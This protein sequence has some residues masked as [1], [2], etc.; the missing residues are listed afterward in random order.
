MT[1]QRRSVS[2]NSGHEMKRV[3]LLPVLLNVL[4]VNSTNIV[5]WL[6]IVCAAVASKNCDKCAMIQIVTSVQ[7]GMGLLLHTNDAPM[8]KLIKITRM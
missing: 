4:R 6:F 3:L 2:L 5:R 7:R 8:E 1:N